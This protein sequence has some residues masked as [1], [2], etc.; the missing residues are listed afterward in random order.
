MEI[1]QKTEDIIT[2]TDSLTLEGAS[3][4]ITNKREILT[5]ALIKDGQVLV[6]GGLI[7][8]DEEEVEQKVPLLGDLPL[9]GGL[10]RSTNKSREKKNLMV[11]IHP[12]ILKDQQ[13]SDL[14]SQRRYDFMRDLQK[15]SRQRPVNIDQQQPLI[16]DF[17]TF[18]P[19]NR[20]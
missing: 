3:D 4:I 14:I 16:E 13:H 7:S 19:V 11:F 20:Q 12:V 10:F 2:A 15:G 1:K 8:E 6:L 18:S 5:T 9:L 17:S